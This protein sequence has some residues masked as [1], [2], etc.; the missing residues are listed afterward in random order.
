MILLVSALCYSIPRLSYFF[1]IRYN[2]LVI[3]RLQKDDVYHIQ[4]HQ[5]IINALT[6]QAIK[7]AVIF[8]LALGLIVMALQLTRKK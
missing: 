4:R 6:P 1:V 8:I 2:R 3:S 5:D 7:G